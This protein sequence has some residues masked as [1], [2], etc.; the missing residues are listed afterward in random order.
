MSC[1]LVSSECP[2]NHTPALLG[3]AAGIILSATAVRHEF[4]ALLPHAR[5]AIPALFEAH[6]TVE[7][8]VG[9][10]LKINVFSRFY[11]EI[12][13]KHF[14]ASNNGA[15]ELAEAEAALKWLLKPKHGKLGQEQ[16][17]TVALP[18]NAQSLP[19]SWFW[20]HYQAME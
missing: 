13:F 19:F 2:S 8:S 17:L 9:R 7:P 12:L 11:A 6:S 4:G 18:G 1:R 10:A 15:L 3:R 5:E 20:S 14:D 16:Q